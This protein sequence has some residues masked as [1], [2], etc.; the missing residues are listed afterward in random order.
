MN[1]VK[2]I[3]VIAHGYSSTKFSGEGKVFYETI[4]ALQDSK[5]GKIELITFSKPRENLPFDVRYV[6]PFRLAKFD[7][8]QR[9][10]TLRKARS[11]KPSL[12]LNLS[13]TLLK[14]SDIAPHIAYSAAPA[15]TTPSKY[16]SS[17]FWRLYLYPFEK[18]VKTHL[19]KDAIIISNSYY[20]AKKIETLGLSVKKVIYPPVDVEEFMANDEKG[21]REEAIIT[22]ARIEKGK[23]IEN[24]IEIARLT[25]LKTYIVGSLS[26]K[27]YLKKLREL[28]KGLDVHFLTDLPKPELVRL[29]HKVSVYFH[30][31]VGE[32]FGIP[33]VEAMA[34]GVIPIVPSESGAAEI[35]PGELTYS[36]LEEA[37]D[38][39][40]KY[41]TD[42]NKLRRELVSR[43]R[44]FSSNIFR[45]KIVE[46]VMET[47]GI[48]N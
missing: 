36:N 38:K 25:R 6:V 39:I 5:I 33:V 11:I 8:Y 7:K 42:D 12:F 16:T 28:S 19:D 3:A 31:T 29:M 23:M 48:N 43:S 27:T 37:A 4:K 30:P 45:N 46:V 24:T 40:K 18:Y 35:V 34:S 47:L 17:K 44:D 9:I 10:L 32:H 20:S 13:G 14:L 15:F 1:G 41:I 21:K 2:S 26:D 22:I